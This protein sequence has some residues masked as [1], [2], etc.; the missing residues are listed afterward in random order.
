MDVQ[1]LSQINLTGNIT[2]TPII[3]RKWDA[4]N[5]NDEA[6]D[7]FEIVGNVLYSNSYH[8][9]NLDENNN[10]NANFYK[11]SLNTKSPTVLRSFTSHGPYSFGINQET[12]YFSDGE[13]PGNNY[14]MPL[15]DNKV[16]SITTN[17]KYNNE[18]ISVYG[19]NFDSN[20]DAYLLSENG[21]GSIFV[22]KYTNQQLLQLSDLSKPA[23]FNFF[24][25]PVVD[26]LHI[27]TELKDINVYDANGD[28]VLKN[29]T[30]TKEINLRHLSPGNYILTGKDA[31]QKL[32]TIKFIKK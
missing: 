13:G 18:G 19:W 14:K 7:H 9:T 21:N 3:N 2:K 27:S 30:N 17:F 11:V 6:F 26:V 28:I 23:S 1:Q 24:P 29:P 5:P 8:Y 4:T 20:G 10:Y 31:S 32:G 22:F 15:D 25:N 12:F 16:S